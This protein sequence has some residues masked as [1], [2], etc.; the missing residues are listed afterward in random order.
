MRIRWQ[1]SR[2]G[3]RSARREA[4]GKVLVYWLLQWVGWGCYFYAQASGEVIFAS[5]PWSKA[6]ALWGTVGL[7]GMGCTHVLKLCIKRNGWLSL[8]PGAMLGRIALATLLISVAV[9]GVTLAM[10]Q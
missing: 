3:R 2:L 10:S 5:Q 7:A 8:P 1:A 4:E 9:H 6:G